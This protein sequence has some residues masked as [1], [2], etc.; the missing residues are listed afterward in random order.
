MTSC[1]NFNLAPFPLPAQAFSAM[2]NEV[3]W[4]IVVSFFFAKV[5]SVM[6]QVLLPSTPLSYNHC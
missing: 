4:L 1:I 6:T 2:T 3:I 5:S